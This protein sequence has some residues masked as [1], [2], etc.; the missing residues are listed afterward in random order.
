M[1]VWFD[2]QV[3][4]CDPHLSALEVRFSRRC[5][6]QI[7]VY[8]YLNIISFLRS[9]LEK[10]W[11]PVD[12]FSTGWQQECQ[13]ALKSLHQLPLME[14]TFPSLLFLHRRPFSCLWCSWWP[15]RPTS[16]N[17]HNTQLN[18]L[19]HIQNSL[20]HAVVNAPKFSRTSPILKSV[21]VKVVNLYSTTSWEPHL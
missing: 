18:R 7:D 13:P 15:N 4:L 3:T 21:K 5:A 14:C 16:N 19:Q 17:L 6:I 11:G 1:Q 9:L 12:V 10:G 8:L 20:A 2:W